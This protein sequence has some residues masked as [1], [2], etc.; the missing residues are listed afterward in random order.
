MKVQS[1]L[2]GTIDYNF[3]LRSQ[4]YTVSQVSGRSVRTVPFSYLISLAD[5]G[6]VTW[7]M[8]NSF[9]FLPFYLEGQFTLPLG[10][11]Q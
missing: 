10:E 5:I 3:Y 6:K 2:S 11:G 9:P 1:L 4:S 8:H 7:L